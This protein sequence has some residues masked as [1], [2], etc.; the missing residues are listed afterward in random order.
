[1][2]TGTMTMDVFAGTVKEA[3]SVYFED[4]T[5]QLQEVTKNNGR[6]LHGISIREKDSNIAPTI[7]LEAFF[8][9]YQDGR[10]FVDIV[11]CP[12]VDLY[13]G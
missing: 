10:S 2:T 9:Q 4:C 6:I 1:M 13:Q 12:P 8:D 5:I 7:Y 11:T 3:P